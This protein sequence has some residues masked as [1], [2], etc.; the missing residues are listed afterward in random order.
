MVQDLWWQEMITDITY[1][2]YSFRACLVFGPISFLPPMCTSVADLRSF[3]CSC[4]FAVFPLV[5]RF[6]VIPWSS[7]TASLNCRCV[8][9]ICKRRPD[10]IWFLDHLPQL[11]WLQVKVPRWKL[12]N[13][14]LMKGCIPASCE[15]DEPLW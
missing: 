4:S 6:F 3:V 2:A 13:K 9:C 10:G 8:I 1:C 11:P 15:S 7:M 5:T 12:T 14:R